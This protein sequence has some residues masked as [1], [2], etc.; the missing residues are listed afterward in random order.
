MPHL[1][2]F[3]DAFARFHPALRH[4]V[5]AFSAELDS[6]ESPM[7][8]AVAAGVVA[9]LVSRAALATVGGVARTWGG[10]SHRYI[11]LGLRDH[12]HAGN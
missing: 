7:V 12:I 9:L 1:E 5:R 11:F 2:P 8:V 3:A 4:Q 10:A 6:L